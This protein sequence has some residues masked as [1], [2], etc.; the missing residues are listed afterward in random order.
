MLDFDVIVI[1]G[2]HAG[3][4]AASAVSRS[5]GRCALVT[6]RADRIGTMSCNPAV[7]G[8]AKGQM[9]REVDAL[10]G[11]QGRAIDATGIQ[12]RM[13]NRSKGPAVQSPR[14]QADKYAYSDWLQRAMADD[15]NI[16][17]VEGCAER[18]VAHAAPVRNSECGMRNEE[19]DAGNSSVRHS[20]L[21]TPHWKIAGVVL[22]DGRELRASAV[23]VTTG[24][25]L[26]GL[27]HE[28]ERKTAGG[29]IGEGAAETLSDSLR[30]LGIELG[31]LKTGTC[32]RLAAET[33][34]FSRLEVQPGDA[35]P[36]PFSFLNDRVDVEQL[37]CWITWT[38]A[39][40]HDMIRANLHRAPMYSGQIASTGPRYCPS[41]ETKIVRFADK[42]RHQIFLEPESR[43]TNEI[44]CNGISTSL[45]RD[46]QEAMVHAIPGLERAAILRFGY[47]VEYDFAPPTQIDAT[48]MAKRVE[49]LFLAGQI[50]GTSG[51][52][53]A[54]G[55][56]IVAG[57]NA[58]RFA[59]GRAPITIGRDQAYIGVMI[60]DL[61]TKGTEEPYRMFTSRAEHRLL[62]RSDNA[63]QRLTP[64]AEAWGVAEPARVRR[65][66]DKQAA[67]AD[68]MRRLEA[69]RI[70]SG[71]TGRD[72]LRR[73][74]ATWAEL[75]ETY[76]ALA[77]ANAS[78]EVIRQ[79]EIAC[80]YA[81][82]IEQSAR[83][84]E[85]FRRMEDRAIPHG[86]DF[87]AVT[88]L[89]LEAREKLARFGPRSLGQ[90]GRISGISPSDL[91]VLLV[92]LER[93]RRAHP[94]AAS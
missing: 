6:L 84:I 24:T 34:D 4:E 53:E 82:Y 38:H 22:A 63:D 81:G 7:G 37:N 57:V 33:V 48:L 64:L 26:R 47:A 1:G 39:E 45:P 12:F 79:V 8:L 55:Q 77:G 42:T 87:A 19:T 46:V 9:T 13:L 27:M 29:R 28:G 76:P 14:A 52:E 93:H 58:A 88:Q 80:R 73:P 72:L 90:A 2:G 41:I 68:C 74:G 35:E 21:H 18:L 20:A 75:A 44:Y 71:R 25:F 92:H 91:A 86:F 3:T 32:P 83:Q 65:L 16:T 17:V 11:L 59:A 49:G 94:P 61:V 56:G 60:D 50:N 66:A 30:E 67:I 62:L 69:I 5:G 31:R 51:Y 23:V 54:A 89:R 78:A 43:N 15:P 36:V 10:G 85:R 40:V 70:D